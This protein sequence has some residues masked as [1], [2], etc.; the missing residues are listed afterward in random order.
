MNDFN[1]EDL[2]YCLQT[3]VAIRCQQVSKVV[4]EIRDIFQ[5]LTLDVSSKDSRFQPILSCSY[6]TDSIK[7]QPAILAKWSALL[8]GQHPYHP[9]IQVLSPTFF[10]IYVPLF[11]LTEYKDVKQKQWRYYTISG[12]KLLTPVREPEKRHQWLRLENFQ[13]N[14]WGWNNAD[15]ITEGDIVPA[16]VMDV[17]RD[18]LKNATQNCKLTDKVSLLETIGPVIRVAVQTLELQVEAELVPMVELSSWPKKARWPRFL[19]R[20]LPR[21]KTRCVKSFGFNL[22]AQSNYH[23]QLSFTRSERVLLQG[24]DEDGGCRL[25]C[26][27]VLRQLKEDVWCPSS[28]PVITSYH[29]QTILLWS[30]EKHPYSKQWRNFKKCFMRLVK[31]LYKCVRQRFLRHY[32]VKGHNLLKNANVHEMDLVAQKLAD[33]LKNP[34]IYFQ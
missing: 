15:V 2:D 28:R 1:K 21:E 33:F 7:E 34:Q 9:A 13:R 3:K 19:Q 24:I 16:K 10:V 12:T 5:A 23:W 27:R 30:C 32:F 31:K 8:N 4:E 22:T 20:W 6:N 25:K 14:S 29:L 18:L 17:F 26:F 11:G